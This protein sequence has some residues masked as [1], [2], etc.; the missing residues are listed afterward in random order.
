MMSAHPTEK[1]LAAEGLSPWQ[2]SVK[3]ILRTQRPFRLAAK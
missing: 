2:C 3:R 1:P